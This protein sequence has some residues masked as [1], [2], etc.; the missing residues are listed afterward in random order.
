MKIALIMGRGVE[1]C[2]VTRNVIEFQKHYSDSKVFATNDKKWPRKDSMH[3]DR[4]EF[5]CATPEQMLS[6]VEEINSNFDAAIIYS[7]PSLKHNDK[8][9]NNFITLLNSLNVTKAMIQV[10]H[11]NASIIRNA[12]LADVCNSMDIIM[13]HSLHGSFASWCDKNKVSTPLITMGVG[14]DYDSHRNKWWK[15]IEAQ[16][17][18]MIKWIGRCAMWKGPVE[19]IKLHNDFLRQ[20]SFITTLEG[21]EASVQSLLITHEDGFNKSIKRDVQEFIRG[22]NRDMAKQWYNNEIPGTAPYL[23]PEYKNEEC[24]ER[25]SLSAF[26]SDLYNLKPQYYGNNIEYCHAEVI[27]SGTVPIFHKHFGDHIIHPKTGNPAT[28]DNSGVVWYNPQ[29]PNDCANQIIE[30]SN[31]SG[32]RNDMRERAFEYWKSHSDSSIVFTDIINRVK[33]AKQQPRT[34]LNIERFFA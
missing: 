13:T 28:K 2:G 14:F 32:L 18:K 26:G 7:V 1:G 11:N 25:L 5:N 6:V 16:N 8:C 20:E 30:I 15:P 23:Y 29:I 33:S 17:P 10:D 22:K 12:R 4:I 19:L 31:D 27:A 24:M 9:I 21:L 34:N 3:L